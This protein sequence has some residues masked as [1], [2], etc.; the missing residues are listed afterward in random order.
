MAQTG[1]SSRSRLSGRHVD[2][3]ADCVIG[4]VA[5]ADLWIALAGCAVSVVYR[6]ELGFIPFAVFPGCHISPLA[7]C[8]I[9]AVAS[10]DLW[11][12]FAGDVTT[13]LYSC[14]S[15]ITLLSPWLYAFR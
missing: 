13:S 12:A 11:A 6:Y 2:P 4:A 9:G 3:P 15:Y 14:L 1:I 8:I 5:S 10:A 7:D